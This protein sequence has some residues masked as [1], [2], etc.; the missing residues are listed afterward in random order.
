MLKVFGVRLDNGTE[1]VIVLDKVN[2]FVR[3]KE[4]TL[5]V[6]YDDGTCDTTIEDYDTTMDKL[7]DKGIIFLVGSRL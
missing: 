2:R 6:Y 3:S 7:I 1:V 4:G 5:K